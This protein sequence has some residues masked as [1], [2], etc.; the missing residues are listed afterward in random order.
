CCV[1][2]IFFHFQRNEKNMVIRTVL[3]TFVLLTLTTLCLTAQE[4]RWQQRVEYTMDVRLDVTTHKLTGTQKL[5]YHNNSPD[6]LDRV[7]Y[8]LYFNAFQPG[9]MMDVRSRTIADP[10][11]RVGNRIESL[12]PS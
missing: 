11:K 5:V 6:T 2:S 12:S 1:D 4:Y 8:H 7:Y 10:D 3:T 9:S